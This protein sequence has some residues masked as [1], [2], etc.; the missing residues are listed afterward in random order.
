MA[1]AVDVLTDLIFLKPDS[2]Y[3]QEKPYRLRYDPGD[4]I[5]RTNCETQIQKDVPVHDIRGRETEYTLARNGFEV[6]TLE[7]RLAP[8]DFYDR[9]KVKCVY[10]EELRQLLQ[11]KLGAKRVEILEHGV[12][13]HSAF[14]SRCFLGRNMKEEQQTCQA[15]FLIR[16]YIDS[17]ETRRISNLDWKRLR[18]LAAYLYHPHWYAFFEKLHSC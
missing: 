17:E 12:S 9:E 11:R 8:E 15:Q 2:K 5:P 4:T 10:Y 13:C 16:R 18:L 3:L 1:A 6:A 7:S 14:F